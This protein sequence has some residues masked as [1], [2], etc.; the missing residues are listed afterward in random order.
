MPKALPAPTE[1]L[2]LPEGHAYVMVSVYRDSKRVFLSAYDPQ[3]SFL[4]FVATDNDSSSLNELL[5]PNS[6]ESRNPKPK[7]SS[8]QEVYARLVELLRFSRDRCACVCGRVCFCV[9]SVF[10]FAATPCAC[11]L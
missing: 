2:P 11:A 10:A 6:A 8:T 7:P 3:T 1:Q 9:V 4:R 5:A